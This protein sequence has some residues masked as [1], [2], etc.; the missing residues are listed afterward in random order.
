MKK[1]SIVLCVLFLLS[2]C[3]TTSVKR[4]ESG[5]QNDL[6]GYWNAVDVKIACESLI[7]DCL[8]SARVNQEINAKKNKRPVVIVGR[9]KNASDEQIDTEIISSTMETVIFNSGKLDFVAGGDI[10]DALRAE[11]QDQLGNASEETAKSI[12]KE[13]GADFMLTG[14]LRTI[15]DRDGN[16]SIRTYFVTAELTNI[17]TNARLWIGQ[18]NSI[19]KVITRPKN[20]F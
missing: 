19:T 13:T 6:S 10:R 4:V 11:R 17:E 16:R 14:S 2:S 12:G 1:T 3:A 8:S 20:K 18:N 9:F 5:S 15:V 7:N